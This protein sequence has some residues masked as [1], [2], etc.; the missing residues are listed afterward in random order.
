MKK[1]AIFSAIILGACAHQVLVDTTAYLQDSQATAKQFVEQL[2][3]TL[4][5]QIETGGVPS[6]IP[7]CKEIAPALA[8]QYSTESKLVKRVS[9][10]AR[11]V[12]LGT[13]DAWEQDA[14]TKLTAQIAANPAGQSFEV[15]EVVREN[16][17]QYFRYAKAIR[18]QPMCLQCH[19]QA[20]DIKP[21]IKQALDEHYPNDVAT[22]YKAGDLRGAVSIKHKIK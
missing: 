12:K 18:A 22:G 15:S 7:V 3:G 10:K 2:G 8:K 13:P 11:N 19:G 16:D 9:N 4:K 14:L 21:E 6:A 1:T 5:K 17:G 20:Q